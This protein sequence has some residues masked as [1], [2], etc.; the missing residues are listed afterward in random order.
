MANVDRIATPNVPQVSVVLSTDGVV[1]DKIIASSIVAVTLRIMVLPFHHLHRHHHL[2]H[3]Q[4]Q[5][6]PTHNVV[7]QSTGSVHPVHVAQY[8]DG[9][10]RVEIIV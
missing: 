9:V 2:H 6:R 3:R 1:Q 8:M 10:A 4:F 5:S 7:R